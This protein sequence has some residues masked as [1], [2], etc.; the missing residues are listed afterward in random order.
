MKKVKTLN[1]FNPTQDQFKLVLTW[2]LGKKLVR[3]KESEEEFKVMS[4]RASKF[5]KKIRDGKLTYDGLPKYGI[6]DKMVRSGDG[7]RG[8]KFQPYNYNTEYITLLEM[9]AKH[10]KPVELTPLG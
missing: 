3:M 6:F 2:M 1:T 5:R 8:W 10:V 4:N 9:F 7:Y